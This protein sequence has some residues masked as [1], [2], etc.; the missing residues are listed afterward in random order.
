[1]AQRERKRGRGVQTRWDGVQRGVQRHGKEY[2]G[3]RVPRRER[4]DARERRVRGA[5]GEG[6]A[7]GERGS[8]VE[9]ER[10]DGGPWKGEQRWGGEWMLQGV[11]GQQNERDGKCECGRSSPE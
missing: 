2:G 8:G 3:E 11:R 7:G 1:M 9:A 6:D 5:V 4:V 10:G